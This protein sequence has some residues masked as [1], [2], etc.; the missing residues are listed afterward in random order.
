MDWPSADLI[1]ALWA[2]GAA[3][4]NALTNI[5]EQNAGGSTQLLFADDDL[6]IM[7]RSGAG[8]QTGLV[9]LPE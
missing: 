8:E 5:H 9:L 7:Q 3:L 6:Y 2:T 4:I 1:N